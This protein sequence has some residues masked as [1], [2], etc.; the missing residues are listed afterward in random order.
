MVVGAH[1]QNQRDFEW[2][3]RPQSK[4][5]QRELNN[6]DHTFISF[7]AP[8]TLSLSLTH[9]RCLLVLLRFYFFNKIIEIVETT[10]VICWIVFVCV[11]C[12][13]LYSWA[14]SRAVHKANY[15]A[16]HTAYS[17]VCWQKALIGTLKIAAVCYAVARSD[18]HNTCLF[19]CCCYRLTVWS[20]C[21]SSQSILCVFVYNL[22]YDPD[23]WILE[24]TVK[25]MRDC[26]VRDIRTFSTNIS[27]LF[28]FSM[29][30]MWLC[31]EIESSMNNSHS[32][33][34]GIL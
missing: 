18:F 20:W 31:R 11:L 17:C 12:V 5:S 32:L 3:N 6:A 9:S 13:H 33:P 29:C 23:L 30:G 19:V 28:A 2:I 7:C 34:F 1:V 8:N 15:W 21:V 14:H 27:D 26:F 10:R 16:M 22:F 25:W 4:P 24:E